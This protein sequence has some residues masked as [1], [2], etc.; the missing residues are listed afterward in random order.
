[1]KKVEQI[2]N[3]EH[4][5]SQRRLLLTSSLG[6]AAMGAI[7]LLGYAMPEIVYAAALT[8]EERDKMTPDEIIE[9]LKQGND[10][11]RSN[12]PLRHDFLAQKRASATGQYPAAAI[13]SCIDSRAPAEIILDTGIGE[14]YNTRVAGNICNVDILGGLEYACAATGAKVILVLGHTSCGAVKGAIDD[15]KLGNL[16]EL[17]DKI[18]PAIAATTYLGER[19]AANAAFVDEVAK[20][21]VKMT[22]DQIRVSSQVLADLEK[23]GKLKM[24]GALYNL[25]S[26]LVEFLV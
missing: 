16:T 2:D 14:T 23:N 5:C 18:K 4:A 20:T 19:V 11:F 24:V 8:K 15:V 25:K 26:G 7:G 9:G 22:L 6:V 17:L 13:L 10:R 21:N 1:M 12:K 3:V